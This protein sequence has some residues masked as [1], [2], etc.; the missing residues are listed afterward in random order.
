MQGRTGK[1]IVSYRYLIPSPDE[2]KPNVAAASL[3]IKSP[4]AD[5]AQGA[6]SNVGL[7]TLTIFIYLPAAIIAHGDAVAVHAELMLFARFIRAGVHFHIGN[8]DGAH[9]L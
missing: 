2:P 7:R 6:F 3:Q 1:P 8:S 5:I 9:L 4:H